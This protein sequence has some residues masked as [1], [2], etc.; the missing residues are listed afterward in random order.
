MGPKLMCIGLYFYLKI[1]MI[2][3]V[4]TYKKCHINSNKHCKNRFTATQIRQ[5]YTIISL[6]NELL[7]NSLTAKN[8]GEPDTKK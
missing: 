1:V 5:N 2:K 7:I 6:F 4:L 3:K 8:I